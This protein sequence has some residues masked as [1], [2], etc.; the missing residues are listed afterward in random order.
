MIVVGIGDAALL[1]SEDQLCTVTLEEALPLLAA[2]KQR[3]RAAAKPTRIRR[4]Q[5]T[6]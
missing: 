2:P 3:G 5:G 6:Q 1:A 4:A